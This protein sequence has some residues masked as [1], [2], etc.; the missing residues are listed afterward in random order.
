MEVRSWMIQDREIEQK[1]K[2]LGVNPPDVEKD[3]IHGWLLSALYSQSQLSP[4]LILKGGNCLRK[5]Y[6]PNRPK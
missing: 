5:S 3:Y 2:E 1:A 4:H 6:L